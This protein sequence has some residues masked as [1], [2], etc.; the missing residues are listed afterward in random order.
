MGKQLN[1][2]KSVI[3]A[4]DDAL[5]YNAMIA[6]N[7]VWQFGQKL[8]YEIVSA[9]QIKIKDGMVTAQGRN[10]VIYPNDVDTLTIQNG[11]SSSKR[12]DL[13]VFE[14]SKANGI[15]TLSLKVIKGTQA[16][17]PVDPT[18]TQDDT[19]VS[20]TVYQ[21]PLYRVR[22]NGINIEGVDD[23][24]EYISSFGEMSNP[25]LLVNTN[26]KH[27]INSKGKTSYACF[28]NGTAITQFT[29]D[30]WK[31]Y[32]VN[33]GI[34][35]GNNVVFANRDTKYHTVRQELKSPLQ[36]GDYTISMYVNSI[37]GTAMLNPK[38]GQTRGQEIHKGLNV[39]TFDFDSADEQKHNE[40]TV[41]LGLDGGCVINVSWIKLEKGKISTH[42]VAEDYATAVAR[43]HP[44]TYGTEVPSTLEDG[45]IFFL[46][47]E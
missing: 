47:K 13:I 26:F 20:G 8:D 4:K 1:V 24:R 23:L 6:K 46:I 9:N 16:T 5:F 17:N 41:I 40:N 33:V 34:S 3:S 44:I 29:I 22:L 14:V 30:K 31:S 27:P 37:Q 28:E 43:C 18:L 19:L 21:M 2:E 11:V 39:Y 45:D 42:Y 15:E 36:S 35:E 32:G 25:N 38:P 12:N 10:Y 7:G